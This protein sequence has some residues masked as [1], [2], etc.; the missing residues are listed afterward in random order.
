MFSVSTD[1]SKSIKVINLLSGSEWEAT[2][3]DSSDF[4]GQWQADERT[5]FMYEFHLA[6]HFLVHFAQYLSCFS[7]LAEGVAVN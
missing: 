4:C 3:A 1:V 2:F 7:P 6:K 5:T